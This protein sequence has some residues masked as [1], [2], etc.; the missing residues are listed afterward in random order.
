MRARALRVAI[1]ALL[2]VAGCTGQEPPRVETAAVARGAVTQTVAAPARV[3]AAAHQDVAA[4]VPGVVVALEARSGDR[5]RGGQTVVELSSSQVELA[6]E[7]A[8][9]AQA[10]AE[11]AGDIAI[12]ARAGAVERSFQAAVAR[13]DQRV[14]P[15]LR[16]ARREAARGPVAARRAARAAIDAVGSS[17]LSTRSSLVAT[18]RALARQQRGVARSLSAALNEAVAAATAPQAA[19]ARA[20]AAA[21]A[22]QAEAERVVAPFAGVVELG[23]AAAAASVITNQTDLTAA[24]VPTG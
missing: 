5:V 12:P 24:A 6:L 14:R 20:A 7:Q 23:A 17:Y 22:E 18:G 3:E 11:S 8:E 21:A 15:R 13:L 10:A 9:A 1:C 2:A 16:A 19:Q 4:E